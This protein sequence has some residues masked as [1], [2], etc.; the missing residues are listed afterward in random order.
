MSII[1][2]EQLKAKFEGG[3]YPGSADYINL[4]DTLASLPESN[5]GNVVL[6]GAGAPSAGTG[7]NGD[8]YINTSNYDIYGPKTAGAWGSATSLVGPTGPTGPTGSTGSTGAQGATGSTGATGAGVVVGGTTGQYLTKIDGTNY[9]TQWSTLDLSG[10][11]DVV[12]DVSSTEIG[13]LNGVTSSI[14]TQ[15]DAKASSSDLTTHG[16]LTEAHGATGAVVGTTNAQTLTNKTLTSPIITGAIFNDG[17]IV[18][19]GA[20]A[21]AHETTFTITDPTADRTITF[22]NATGTVALAENVA[23]LSGATFSGAVS[24]TDLTLSGNLTVNGTTT[25]INSTSL[26][27][28]DKNIVLG[29]TATPSDVTADG[30]GITIKGT[31]DKTLNWVDATDAFTSSEHINLAS[32]KSYY[33][34]GT[35]LKD[36]SETLTN[37]TLTNPTLT[38]PDIGVATATSINGTTIPASK[39]LV[40][41]DSTAYVVPSQTGN[42]NKFLKTDGTTSTWAAVAGALAQ[43]TE[44]SSPDDGQI[45]VDTDGSVVGQAMTRWSKVMSAGVTAVSG[46]DDS[47]VT[48]TYTS[49]YEQVYR[50]GVL[51]SRGNDY[52]ATTGTSITLIDATLANDVIEVI[53]SSVLGIAD[54]YTQTQSN[55][56]YI[57]KAL[58]TTTGD[59]IYASAAN[60]PARLGIGTSG[61]VL[62]V[63]SGVPAW[64]TASSGGMTLLSTTT[65]SGLTTSITGISQSYKN[66]QVIIT[67]TNAAASYGLDIEAEVGFN[68]GNKFVGRGTDGQNV[69]ASTN[70]FGQYNSIS[71]GGNNV[72]V[73]NIYDYTSARYKIG[74]QQAIYANSVG[75]QSTIVIGGWS[76]GT[77]IDAITITSDKS[78]TAGTCLIYGVN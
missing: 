25:N 75:A 14:Q 30:G 57:G 45:W 18:F 40:A 56:A 24:G 12:T 76:G 4:I 50:N 6:N 17:S 61:Q 66:L 29:D 1:T 35:L 77:V 9:N 22:P 8:F 47:S 73:M 53:G 67:G 62:A 71:T 36:V 69:V 34:N 78:I 60:T 27:V 70:Y 74:V 10:K 13:Y 59:M 46:L 51:L 49:G 38:T 16:N 26:V 42:A 58:T 41:T 28:E 65:L 44:P 37:K 31:T 52:T 72:F 68:Q 23:A 39:T 7:A 32:G 64:T 3:D 63:S 5:S 19:E 33:V 21:D 48:L 20:T 2:I 55:A 54:V 11:Q 15:L 43:P